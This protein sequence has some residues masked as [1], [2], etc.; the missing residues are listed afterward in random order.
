MQS[1]TRYIPWNDLRLFLGAPTDEAELDELLETTPGVYHLGRVSFE[2]LMSLYSLADLFVMP[3][4]PVEGDQEGFGL[5]A[6]EASVR[7]TWVVA[8]GIEGITEAVIEGANGTL[9]PPEDPDRWVAKIRELL[10]MPQQEL[11]EWGRRG[12]SYTTDHFSWGRMVDGYKAV[13]DRYI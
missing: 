1:V 3:N 8:S 2:D 12:Q 10:S 13:F 6:L 5:V 11:A 4:I 7:G 9:L